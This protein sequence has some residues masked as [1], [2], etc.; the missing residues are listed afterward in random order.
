VR[1]RKRTK[2]TKGTASAG[3]ET[4]HLQVRSIYGEVRSIF[5]RLN[6][7]YGHT[8]M[9]LGRG[10]SNTVSVIRR[11]EVRRIFVRTVWADPICLYVMLCL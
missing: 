6:N 1:K 10:F 2:K 5:G 4:H 3:N 9:G 8:D 7:A 11:I